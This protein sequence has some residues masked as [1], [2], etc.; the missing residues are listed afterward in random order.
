MDRTDT[1]LQGQSPGEGIKD[2]SNDSYIRNVLYTEHFGGDE[3]RGEFGT[4]AA[5]EQAIEVWD[6]LVRVKKPI[7]QGKVKRRC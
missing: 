6:A 7:A 1:E 3:L 4:A 5:S 2:G